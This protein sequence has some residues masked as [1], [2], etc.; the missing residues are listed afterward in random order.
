M[1]LVASV[2]AEGG[3]VLGERAALTPHGGGRTQAAEGRV[4]DLPNALARQVDELPGGVERD[5]ALVGDVERAAAVGRH[6]IGLTVGEVQPDV[7]RVLVVVEVE[8]VPAADEG[9]WP[10]DVVAVVPCARPLV[11]RVGVEAQLHDLGIRR[12][13]RTAERSGSVPVWCRQL[14]VVIVG[15]EGR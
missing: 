3:H 1:A 15:S 2:G 13:V 9:A 14:A 7:A 10:R 8:V 12:C 4:L 5:A 6:L 11:G